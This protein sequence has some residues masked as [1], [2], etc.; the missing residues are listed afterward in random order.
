MFVTSTLRYLCGS[1]LLCF[2]TYV[3]YLLPLCCVLHCGVY[4]TSGVCHLRGQILLWCVT[5]AVCYLCDYLL[6][7][8]V[9]SELL[10][11]Y[12]F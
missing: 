1:L 4:V 7:R 10:Y 9:I 2:G 11:L 5:F 6:L 3:I 8:F 12:G